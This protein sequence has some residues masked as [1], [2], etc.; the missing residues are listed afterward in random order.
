MKVELKPTI[1]NQKTNFFTRV[2]KFISAKLKP[3]AKDTFEKGVNKTEKDVI[4]S[5]KYPNWCDGEDTQ[6]VNRTFA[7]TICYYPE[8]EKRMEKMTREERC[9]Y[10]YKLQKDGRYYEV[11]STQTRKEFEEYVRSYG[12]DP[13]I[14][15]IRDN[16]WK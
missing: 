12:L 13:E 14:F 7:K 1:V 2:K 10:K 9:L 4:V 11:E 6:Y 15:Y 8:D 3:L 5:R 16:T